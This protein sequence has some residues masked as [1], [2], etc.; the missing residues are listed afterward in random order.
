MSDEKSAI[1]PEVERLPLEA[2]VMD[3]PVS[4]L[5]RTRAARAAGRVLHDPEVDDGPCPECGEPW[6][7]NERKRQRKI[8]TQIV[9]YLF[10]DLYERASLLDSDPPGARFTSPLGWS[11]WLTY[12]HGG[13]P[14]T[15]RAPEGQPYASTTSAD[16]FFLEE[17]LP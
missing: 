15:I 16:V 4:L 5:E 8:K 3:E 10:S 17:H 12:G 11:V 1:A 2:V 14:L 13:I 9:N 6:P 7:C